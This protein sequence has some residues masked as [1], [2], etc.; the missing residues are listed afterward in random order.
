MSSATISRIDKKLQDLPPDSL[1]P[2]VFV[3]LKH[4]RSSWVELGR[5]L[6]EVA[7]SKAY[8]EWGYD[9]VEVY[10]ARELGLK[11]P[12]VKKLMLS[13]NYMKAREPG[14]LEDF[15]E[16]GVDAAGNIPDYQT[17]DLLHRASNNPEIDDQTKD[18]F[19]RMAFDGEA[20]EGDLRKQ[21]RDQ[22]RSPGDIDAANTDRRREIEGILRTARALRRKIAVS[23][24]V[25]EGLRDRLEQ[26]LVEL[27]AL[28]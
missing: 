25:P 20:E 5:L 19:H 27:E 13:Y 18:R 16:K 3:A 24:H 17:V 9:D 12:T 4:F 7:Y 28:D 26:I 6:T 8:V 15:E 14:R 11:S 10:C 21:I 1:R 22:L 2:K 23:H